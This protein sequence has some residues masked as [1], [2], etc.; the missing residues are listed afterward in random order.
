MSYRKERGFTLPELVIVMAVIG[1]VIAALFTFVN[2]SVRRYVALQSESAAFGQLAKQTQRIAQVLRGATDITAA[3]AD[4]I[5]AY[6]Y[7]YPNDSYV[8]LI[9]YYKGANNTQ[10]LADVT[11]MTANPPIG[12]PIT[13]QKRTYTII[14]KFS[15]VAG[16]NTFTYLDSV[17]NPLTVP[18]ADLHTIKGIKVSL[19]VPADN[20]V[21][22]SNST[23]TLQVSLRNRKTNL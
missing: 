8:S 6:A 11:P 13:A 7:F 23:V 4:D 15:S 20:V 2:T 3:S 5:T 17:G 14:D 18:I 22:N 16:V 9:H 10:I 12:T 21:A 19:S 1:V